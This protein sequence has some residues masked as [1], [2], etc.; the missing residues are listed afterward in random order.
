MVADNV[1]GTNPGLATAVKLIES[2]PN[3][4][5]GQPFSAV[6]VIATLL[7]VEAPGTATMVEEFDV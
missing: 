1:G 2:E 5:P 4:G 6:V 3:P 7:P